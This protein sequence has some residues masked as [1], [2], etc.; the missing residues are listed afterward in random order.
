MNSFEGGFTERV[1][2]TNNSEHAVIHNPEKLDPRQETDFRQNTDYSL[3]VANKI[4]TSIETEP[5]TQG[6]ISFTPHQIDQIVEKE[7]EKPENLTKIQQHLGVFKECN[8]W[9]EVGDKVGKAVI[10]WQKER[11]V[12]GLVVAGVVVAVVEPTPVMEFLVGPA[13]VAVGWEHSKYL[14]KVVPKELISKFMKID[15]VKA[16]KK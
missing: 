15:P 9:K 11:M 12:I 4:N 14:K 6:N 2:E 3:L 1:P 8:N 10:E 7:K 13:L 16:L 5:Q